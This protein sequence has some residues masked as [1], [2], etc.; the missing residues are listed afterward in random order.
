MLLD[1][2][3]SQTVTLLL[4]QLLKP[5]TG[6][7]HGVGEGGGLG[8]SLSSDL[9]PLKLVLR[10]VSSNTPTIEIGDAVFQTTIHEPLGT[11]LVFNE[12]LDEVAA[13]DRI[14]KCKQ[15]INKGD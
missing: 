6:H 12:K 13:V 11:H 7:D 2:G 3:S 8:A 1:F 14:I 15:I 5:T 9:S 10:N 4:Q